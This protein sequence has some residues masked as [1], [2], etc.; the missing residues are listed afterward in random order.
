MLTTMTTL[1]HSPIIHGALIGWATAAGV[2]Y[3][4]FAQF[5]KWGDLTAY[6]WSIATF[7]WFGGI[8]TGALMG[9]GFGQ[10]LS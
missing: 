10:W 4:A 5:K 2:D 8:V 7:R 9:A 1:L 6:D 3:R